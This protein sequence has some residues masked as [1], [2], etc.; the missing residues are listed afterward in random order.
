M[1]K[2]FVD[3]QLGLDNTRIAYVGDFIN[4]CCDYIPIGCDFEVHLCSDRASSGIGTT[5]VYMVGDHVIKVYCK[6]RALPDVMRSVAHEM[7]HMRQ[8]ETDL[9][10]GPIQDIGGFHEDQANAVAG[11]ALKA[12][13]KSRGDKRFY[14]L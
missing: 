1:R 2:L 8:D 9:I 3:S 6:A 5:G 10:N 7:T 13:A 12:Y 4:F 11:A 14:D